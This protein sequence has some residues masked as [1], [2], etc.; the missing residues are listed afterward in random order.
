MEP[1]WAKM[2]PRW[3]RIRQDGANIGP[4]WANIEAKRRLEADKMFETPIGTTDPG[5]RE[6][7]GEGKPSPF[8]C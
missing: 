6:G 1:R 5:P 4:R 3:A 7:E 2:S 8:G